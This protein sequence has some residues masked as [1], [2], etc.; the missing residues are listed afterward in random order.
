MR[1]DSFNYNQLHLILSFTVLGRLVMLQPLKQQSFAYLDSNNARNN[2]LEI[3][4]Y[5]K[6][7]V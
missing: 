5:F 1:N 6:Y 3:L 2:A 4:C 7:R